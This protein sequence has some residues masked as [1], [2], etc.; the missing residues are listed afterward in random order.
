MEILLLR[1]DAPLM[2][3]GGPLVDQEG[4]SLAFP[5]LSMLTGLLG[6]ALGFDHGDAARLQDLQRRLRYAVRCDRAG[7]RLTDF[8]T[9]DLGLP[10][11]RE[12]AWTTRGTV[13]ER[14]GSAKESTHI[15][16]R[17]YLVDS[18]FTVALTVREAEAEPTLNAIED[19]LRTP[20]RPLFLGRK[21]CL[22]AAPLLFR[23][24]EAPSLVAALRRAPL[25]AGHAID[26][27]AAVTVWADEEE[28]DELPAT[29]RLLGITDERDWANQIHGGMRRL[30]QVVIHLEE[31]TGA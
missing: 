7:G 25:P 1:L 6:N 9:V 5:G 27:K 15:R 30:V 24:V 28:R 10:H 17:E 31:G 18:C 23:R 26:A 4:R 20:E 21:A 2:S 12:G 19:A 11:M 29:Q 13:D 8:H 16:Y 22:P 14:S 3:F